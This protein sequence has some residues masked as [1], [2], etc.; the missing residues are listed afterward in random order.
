MNCSKCRSDIP[1]WVNFCPYCGEKSGMNCPECQ[2]DIPHWVNFCP[3]C[4]ANIA[5]VQE[6]KSSYLPVSTPAS[7]EGV[8]IFGRGNTSF[9]MTLLPGTY[10]V[11][12]TVSQNARRL[13]FSER[14]GADFFIR[15]DSVLGHK[16][17]DWL[18]N[19][20]Y[21]PE[22]LYNGLYNFIARVCETNADRLERGLG[23]VEGV[24][25]ITIEAVEQWT[26]S[27]DSVE[28]AQVTSLPLSGYEKGAQLVALGPGAYNVTATVKDNSF[29]GRRRDPLFHVRIESVFSDEADVSVWEWFDLDGIYTFPV[30]VG[31]RNSEWNERNLF[32]GRQLVSVLSEGQWTINFDSAY[33]G[34][35]GNGDITH[36]VPLDPGVYFGIAK[37]TDNNTLSG[38]EGI[39]SIEVGSVL[40]RQK[41]SSFHSWETAEGIFNFAITIP[42][43]DS[44]RYEG[45]FSGE[46]YPVR[47]RATGYWTISLVPVESAPV[48]SSPL[49][50]KGNGAH[51]VHLEPGTYNI[52]TEVWDNGYLYHSP[53]EAADFSVRVESIIGNSLNMSYESL[54]TSEGRNDFTVVVHDAHDVPD[55]WFDLIEGRQIVTVRAQGSWSIRFDQQ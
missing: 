44:P 15:I 39:F 9:S 3:H 26:I 52:I 18:L 30:V 46:R 6:E 28:L 29:S 54:S 24:Q 41:G 10:I 13:L 11:T 19:F 49:S 45:G 48:T 5:I 43:S 36:L 42:D 51:V 22:G 33:V 31:D 55:V 12:A 37:I 35:A 40:D 1:S 8:M 7:S 47:V 25:S 20:W 50:G 34:L 21:T 38:V 27:F 14:A 16:K 17:Y 23:L 4:G 53:E 2:G 32:E